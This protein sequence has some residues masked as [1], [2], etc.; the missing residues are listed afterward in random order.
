M[1]RLLGMFETA[2]VTGLFILIPIFLAAAVII[3]LVNNIDALLIR[4]ASIT[5]SAFTSL[6]S[7]WSWPS[8]CQ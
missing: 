6:V 2:F 8:C 1:K 7:G 5:G 4:S 3:F